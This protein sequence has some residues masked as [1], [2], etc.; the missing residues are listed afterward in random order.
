MILQDESSD[1]DNEDVA[2]ED[3]E[4]DDEEELLKQSERLKRKM[5]VLGTFLQLLESPPN[6]EL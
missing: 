2:A 5:Y 4:D 6:V 1:S 3:Y